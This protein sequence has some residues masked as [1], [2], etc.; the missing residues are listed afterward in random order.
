MITDIVLLSTVGIRC[1]LVHGGGPEINSWLEKVG[2]KPEFKNGLRVTDGE[3][4][5][6]M[7]L[8]LQLSRSDAQL[9][10]SASPRVVD[11]KLFALLYECQFSFACQLL[12][13][14]S[15]RWC[16][17]VA[18]T[19]RWSASSSRRGAPRW[20]SAGR[21]ATSSGHGR[22]AVKSSHLR[23]QRAS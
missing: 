16:W 7:I 12:R 19:S 3:W 15:S 23:N 2:I 13:W 5:L 14:K 17:E 18:S 6:G 22:W 8:Q 10:L 20:A 1:V 21:T 9:S 4:V 11:G